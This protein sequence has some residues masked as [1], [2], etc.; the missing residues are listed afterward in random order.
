[1]VRIIRDLLVMEDRD[2]LKLALG[3]PRGWLGSGAP[4][5]AT[6]APTHFGRVSYQVAYD[7]ASSVVRGKMTIPSD[8]RLKS[9]RLHVRLP[10]GLKAVAVKSSHAAVIAEVDSAIEWKRASGEISF[11]ATVGCTFSPS[12]L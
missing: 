8:D 10:Q 1:V 12:A 4:V 3:T 5:G 6:N 9:V 11:E 2:C 7:A